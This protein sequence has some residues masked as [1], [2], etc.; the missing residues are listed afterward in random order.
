MFFLSELNQSSHP[1]TWVVLM[2]FVGSAG[3]VAQLQRG[4]GG[5]EG[6]VSGQVFPRREVVSSA[7]VFRV[8]D[9]TSEPSAG[10][11]LTGSPV[12]I[13]QLHCGKETR[14]PRHLRQHRQVALCQQER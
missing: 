12:F 13:L 3:G 1:S 10:L 5:E 8:S 14:P 2:V 9:V 6:P 11:V 7:L 4:A